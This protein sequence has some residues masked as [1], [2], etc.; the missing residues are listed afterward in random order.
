[1]EDGGGRHKGKERVSERWSTV[2]REAGEA[3]GVGTGRE[4]VAEK[5]SQVSSERPAVTI[6]HGHTQQTAFH[7]SHCYEGSP[8]LLLR[9]FP[10]PSPLNASQTPVRNP[11]QALR[12]LQSPLLILDG[13]SLPRFGFTF[14]AKGRLFASSSTSGLPA[15]IPPQL[16]LFSV[17]RYLKTAHPLLFF[18]FPPYS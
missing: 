14:V 11:R 2:A 15:P 1:M 5:K 10:I 16:E 8:T 6:H 4:E 17:P 13:L 9:G 3:A 18:F 7:S 12:Q